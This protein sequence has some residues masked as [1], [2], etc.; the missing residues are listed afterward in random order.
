MTLEFDDV[1]VQMA[2]CRAHAIKLIFRFDHQLV[3][4]MSMS[5]LFLLFGQRAIMSHT[6]PL[7]TCPPDP[8]VEDFAAVE[9]D[10][11]LKLSDEFDQLEVCLIRTKL[12]SDL[13][14]HGY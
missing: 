8:T 3:I 13:I 12:V 1:E 14:G 4:T 5:P 2:E 11:V 9:L 6:A 7:L 10:H